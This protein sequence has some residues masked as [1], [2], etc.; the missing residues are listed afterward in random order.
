MVGVLEHGDAG[1]P[2]ELAGD[3]DAVLNRL[4]SRVDQHGLLGEVAGCALGQ[5]LGD[6]HVL[7]VGRDREQRVGDIAEL[8]TRGGHDGIVGVADRGHADAAPEVEQRVVVDVD[9]DRT[10]G[11]RDVDGKRR[12]HARRDHRAASRLQLR[13]PRPGNG[14]DDAP[15]G[16]HRG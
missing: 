16:R 9:E 11:A 10:V 15:R 4:G 13:G 1:A 12:G 7:L 2:R 6:P 14:R 8:L 3:L 5:E